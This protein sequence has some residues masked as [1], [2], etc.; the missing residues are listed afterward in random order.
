MASKRNPCQPE[1][2]L[3]FELK[4]ALDLLRA[5]K[6]PCEIAEALSRRL[7]NKLL[8]MP[9]KTARGKANG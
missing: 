4:R 3:H 1:M 5:R 6:D 9:L 7:T 2:A 8:H